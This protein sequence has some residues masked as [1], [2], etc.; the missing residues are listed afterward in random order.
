MGTVVVDHIHENRSPVVGHV[1]RLLGE[2]VMVVVAGDDCTPGGSLVHAVVGTA[3]VAVVGLALDSAVVDMSDAL[4][5]GIA[6]APVVAD[7]VALADEN[8]HHDSDGPVTDIVDAGSVAKGEYFEAFAGT[9]DLHC[10]VLGRDSGPGI[11]A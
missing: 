10:V 4:A 7:S 6:Q 8:P 1:D 3:D 2:V 9:T 5:R 11:V